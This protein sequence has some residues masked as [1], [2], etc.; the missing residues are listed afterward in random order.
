M[1][2]RKLGGLAVLLAGAALLTVVLIYCLGLWPE[3]VDVAAS[4]QAPHVVR[5]DVPV[6][7]WKAKRRIIH[8][9]DHHL[10]PRELHEGP[11]PHEQHVAD[12]RAVQLEQRDLLWHLVTGLRLKAVYLEGLTAETVPAYRE[13]AA[14]LK[15]IQVKEIPVL[16]K[17]LDAALTLKAEGARAMEKEIRV[18]LDAHLE[19]VASL[20]APGWLLMTGD[21]AEVR[22]L[23]DAGPLAAADPRKADA[24]TMKARE[25][26]IVG[27]P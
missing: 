12:V 25:D 18:M 8:I 5:V 24:A 16:L 7:L 1:F 10:V 23:D 9:L 4:R 19:R 13:K 20:G 3:P 22:P 2:R 27:M 26:A 21:L 17:Q 14:V 15:E 6:N 11:E